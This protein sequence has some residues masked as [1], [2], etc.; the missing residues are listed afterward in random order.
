[1]DMRVLQGPV[2]VLAVLILV[3]LLNVIDRIGFVLLAIGASLPMFYLAYRLLRS[4]RQ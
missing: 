1:M 4:G 3:G 2:G